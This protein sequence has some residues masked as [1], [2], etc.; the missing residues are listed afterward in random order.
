MNEPLRAELEQMFRDDQAV[1]GEAMACVREHGRD[2]AEYAALAERGRAQ[3]A[4]HVARL[5]EI[6]DEHGW[7]GTS[8]VGEDGSRGAF[9]ALQHADHETQKRLLPLVRDAVARG[10]L[11]PSFLPLI[12]DRVRMRDGEDQLYGTQIARGEDGKP[13]LWPIEDAENV[14]A[15]RAEMELEP[16]AEYLKRFGL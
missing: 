13:R 8:L 7:P 10:E 11:R 4:R 15:R 3:D 5:L 2:S 12:E 14:D 9:F 16:L 6:V 1:R